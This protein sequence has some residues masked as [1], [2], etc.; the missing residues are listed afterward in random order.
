MK[1]KR[2]NFWAWARS[3]WARGRWILYVTEDSFPY[4]YYLRKHPCAETTEQEWTGQSWSEVVKIKIKCQA[5]A[6]WWPEL[7]RSC[8][9]CH[10]RVPLG[11]QSSHH[12]RL[13]WNLAG[14]VQFLLCSCGFESLF[15]CQS[16]R[17]SS[18]FSNWGV[19]G[20]V[21][22]KVWA[23][24]PG[25][26]WKVL[27]V[28]GEVQES[29][30][31]RVLWGS[32]QRFWQKVLRQR[33][34]KK[35]RNEFGFQH[36]FPLLGTSP[37]V[38]L[39]CCR[40]SL[41]VRMTFAYW[42]VARPALLVLASQSRVWGGFG[43]CVLLDKCSESTFKREVVWSANGRLFV[44]SPFWFID[45]VSH[46]LY[47]VSLGCAWRTLRVDH[48]WNKYLMSR[49]R[50]CHAFIAEALAFEG[51][52]RGCV[53]STALLAL[54]VFNL[55]PGQ[56]KQLVGSPGTWELDNSPW[57]FLKERVGMPMSIELTN[58]TS[59]LDAKFMANIWTWF[60]VFFWSVGMTR[61]P[62]HKRSQVVKQ[63][64]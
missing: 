7:W 56:Q 61:F 1:H 62:K 24:V 18:C 55:P 42:G 9:E 22:P 48:K 49:A 20:R 44:S 13:R 5:Y 35:M 41:F 15:Q 31:G 51:H 8:R 30:L 43:C 33:S 21:V 46:L 58:C 37:Q 3:P 50:S 17:L 57:F 53:R 34:G 12:S 4:F 32:G 36:T 52:E 10:P 27:A 28:L 63:W 25:E 38:T 47:P 45:S 60:V 54:G 39:T 29:I 26:F 59:S 19:L 64:N 6:I 16:Q 11:C 23:R 40:G 2:W 14:T